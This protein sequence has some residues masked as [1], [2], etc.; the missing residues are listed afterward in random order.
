VTAIWII[1]E[2]NIPSVR[3]DVQTVES[4]RDEMIGI[5]VMEVIWCLVV[6]ASFLNVNDVVRLLKSSFQVLQKNT[7]LSTTISNSP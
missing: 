3:G 2:T 1:L 5:A 4:F 6:V 7:S